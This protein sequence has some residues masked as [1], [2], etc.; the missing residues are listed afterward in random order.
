MKFII[1]WN[2]QWIETIYQ[3]GDPLTVQATRDRVKL[4][5]EPSEASGPDGTHWSPT[6]GTS[7]LNWFADRYLDVEGYS[8]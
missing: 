2:G 1:H 3:G 6:G 5:G 8:Q 4:I 7:F